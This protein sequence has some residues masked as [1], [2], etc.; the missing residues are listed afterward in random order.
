MP[1]AISQL[2]LVGIL[3]ASAVAQNGRVSC[4]EPANIRDLGLKVV[5][6]RID[7]GSDDFFIYKRLL[8]LTPDRPK[9]GALAP[10]FETKLKE[11]PDDPR[12]LYL[13]GRSLIGKRTP[14]AIVQLN[15][16][17]E[18]APNFPW[19]YLE[20][21]R[22]YFSHNFGD[23]TE[24]AAVIHTYRDLCPADLDGYD[25]ARSESDSVKN[26]EWAQNF[27]RLL[28]N[29]TNQYNHMHWA[30]LWATEFRFAPK[31]DY[32]QLRARVAED[33]K[34]LEGT[35]EPWTRP[36]MADLSTGY[37]LI[38]RPDLAAQIDLRIDP[39][40]E[41][42]KAQQAFMKEVNWN[43][44]LNSEEREN[45]MKAQARAAAQYVAKWPDSAAA[46]STRLG[47]LTHD[48]SWTK[49][50]ME[51]AGLE[52]LRTDALRGFGWTPSPE[53]LNV[54]R[55][56][57]KYGI[58][59]KDCIAMAEESLDEIASG[60]EIA[61]DLYASPNS[62]PGINNYSHTLFFA[63]D[64]IV[65]GSLQLKDFDKTRGAIAK[66][67]KWVDENQPL[68]SDPSTGFFRWRGI[69]LNSSGK[70]AEA[71]GRKMD[72]IAFYTKAIALGARDPEMAKR[73]RTLWDQMDGTKDGWDSLTVMTPPP[74]KPAPK[75]AINAV[76]QIAPWTSVGKPL[77]EMNILD[78][79]GRTWTLDDLRGKT[80]FVTTWATWCVPCRD[81]LP[82]VQ[83]L[84]ELVK[85]R[86][87]VQVITLNADEDP[88]LVEPFLAANRFTFPVLMA[89][90]DY[91]AS[92]ATGELGIPQNWLVDH[93]LILRE[94]STGFDNHILDWPKAML[95]K[96]VSN[97]Q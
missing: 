27:R 71:E 76:Y 87:D 9:P 95:D 44:P 48:Q 58:H 72:A 45:A 35:P 37:M 61:S 50:E 55:Q 22:I 62:K 53:R 57:V 3:G 17:V 64:A 97:R 33:L 21:A 56:W 10:A 92:H 86:N 39:D 94:K 68:Q 41:V 75:P 36:F 31:S 15:R 89:A 20:L 7:A 69:W 28:E 24:L 25:W 11:H 74:S 8:D 6:G 93:A 66:M 73:A 26:A 40:L 43:A 83:K 54:A 14:D 2:L 70:L 82:S 29:N 63:L 81:E 12:Y 42:H 34:R 85:H 49:E 84:Y 46:W 23:L 51:H 60:P 32:P 88:G 90:R 52:L 65:D 67:Q 1:R 77:L 19:T 47:F 59:P 96:L 80:T 91:V 4:L 38:E 78:V 13:Y 16:V 18:L 79:T 30:D 5:R